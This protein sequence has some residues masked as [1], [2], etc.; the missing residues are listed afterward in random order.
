MEAFAQ[1]TV[2]CAADLLRS[3]FRWS[4]SFLAGVRRGDHSYPAVFQDHVLVVAAAAAA[5]AC[6]AAALRRLRADRRAASGSERSWQAATLSVLADPV[7]ASRRRTQLSLAPPTP[8]RGRKCRTFAH[9]RRW[10]RGGHAGVTGTGVWTGL[11][12]ESGPGFW[13]LGACPAR[14]LRD[15]DGKVALGAF[16]VVLSNHERSLNAAFLRILL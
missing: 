14:G 3:A 7:R 1:L 2:P 11:R 5:A 4:P 13:L 16:K 9:R 10:S 12:A 6:V 15:V 8:A